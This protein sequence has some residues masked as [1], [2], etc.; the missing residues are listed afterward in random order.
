MQQPAE[1]TP[2][3]SQDVRHYNLLV[4]SLPAHLEL[5]VTSNFVNA[6]V[7]GKAVVS[8]R[9][10]PLSIAKNNTVV[11]VRTAQG[12]SYTLTVLR[13]S[14]PAP[15]APLAVAGKNFEIKP[16]GEGVLAYSNRKYV[17]ANVPIVLGSGFNFTMIPGGADDVSIEATANKG[18]S[19]VAITTEVAAYT[20]E[21]WRPIPSSGFFHYTDTGS[22]SLTAFERIVESGQRLSIRQGGW[23]GSFLLL[24]AG[25]SIATDA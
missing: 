6:T 22:T 7:D 18:G 1:L 4:E 20:A 19:I 24:P 10:T 21:G 25:T 15:P 3:F 8:G 14:L 9:A 16:F 12:A 23:A 5:T 11:T 17:F 13:P 2:A